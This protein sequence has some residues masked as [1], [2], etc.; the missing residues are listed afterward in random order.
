MKEIIPIVHQV[1]DSRPSFVIE[2]KKP[3]PTPKLTNGK[4]IVRWLAEHVQ[5][6]RHYSGR[7]N[8]GSADSSRGA[9]HTVCP[10]TPHFLE[11][12]EEG[13]KPVVEAL[14]YKG[15]LTYSSCAGHDAY[16]PR[17]VGL[18]FKDAL[19]R[20]KVQTLISKRYWFWILFRQLN[21]TN[22]SSV[23]NMKV[24][25]VDGKYTPLGKTEES[26][27]SEAETNYFNILFYRRFTSWVFLRIRIGYEVFYSK[28]TQALTGKLP[29]RTRLAQ[30][31]A[32]W[33]YR[34]IRWRL[35]RNLTQYIQSDMFP[36]HLD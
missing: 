24:A 15:Y 25:E 13:I 7:I 29:W 8:Y 26:F 16:E 5:N 35:T 6:K 11:N 31:F 4:D 30:H 32:K 10:Y 22:L 28:E 33:T 2:R 18:A 9:A 12:I 36:P 19:A 3:E 14:F 34:H 27:T 20:E 17:Y 23:V 21:L 1:E